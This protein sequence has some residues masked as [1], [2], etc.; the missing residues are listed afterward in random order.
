[1]NAAALK[2]V[3]DLNKAY[4]L[5]TVVR[6]DEIST[7]VIPRMTS[8]SLGLDLILG[9][10]WPC[11]QAVEIV[12]AP[13]NGKTAVA[14]KTIAANQELN[15]EYTAVWVAAEEWVPSY[16]EMCGVDVSRVWVVETNVMEHAFQAVIGFAETKAVD[17]IVIDSLPALVP[18][19][20]DERDMEQMTVG[21]G[22]LMTNKFFRKIGKSLKRSL[23]EAER[24]VLLLVINQW[25]QLI[26]VTH[27]PDKTTPG[28][29]GKDYAYFVRVEVKRDSWIEVGTGD[30]KKKIG[31]GIRLQTLKNKTA[32]PQ[33]RAYI[34]F[35]F[36]NGGEVR[37]GD[38][39]FAKEIVALAVLA[40]VV[41]RKGAWFYYG[42]RKWQGVQALLDDIRQD[43]D[44]KDQIEREVR[45]MPLDRML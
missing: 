44:L 23:T 7:E 14:L 45:S 24:P 10:G 1:M 8:G 17:C 27:G 5:G 16:A 37:R 11:N 9:G 32:R 6:G 33:Q 36:G 39:D 29:Q 15:P 12:G 41:E 2:V 34:D 13:S 38:Y 25:R 26:G 35:Y 18:S 40:E 20:E 3:K 31:Q 19:A 4:G 43:L 30:S 42:D 28:G 21:R 22:A